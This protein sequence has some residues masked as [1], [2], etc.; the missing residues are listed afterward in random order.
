MGKKRALPAT[1]VYLA[2]VI[3][4][5][6]APEAYALT[7]QEQAREILDATGTT[8]GLIV[9]LDCGDLERASFHAEQALNLS[10]KNKERENEGLSRILLGRII[11]K[12]EKSRSDEAQQFIAEGI[13]IL[14]DLK[15][16]PLYAMGYLSL[17][18]FHADRGGTKAA[19]AALKKAESLF[20]D[21]GMDYWLARTQEVLARL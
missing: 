17:G 21:M 20:Q 16:R 4:L 10:F 9:H 14:E 18:E 3:C 13:K 12:K 19:L 8:G 2:T 15:L 11:G 7:P 1:G 6:L 5:L